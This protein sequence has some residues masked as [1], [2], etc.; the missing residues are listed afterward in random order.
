MEMLSSG[1]DVAIALMSNSCGYLHK[2]KPAKTP[3]IGGEGAVQ[4]PLLPEELLA[5]GSFCRVGEKH[6]LFEDVAIGRVPMLWWMVPHSCM[7]M[8]A[9]LIRFRGCLSCSCYDKIS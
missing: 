9:S 2:S 3:A 5:A 4:A 7:H 6:S 1:H 8:W